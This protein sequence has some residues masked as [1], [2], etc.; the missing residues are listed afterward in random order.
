MN[1]CTRRVLLGTL[2]LMLALEVGAAQDAT[3]PQQTVICLAPVAVEAT[4]A[5]M[6]P[7]AAVRDAFMNFLTGPSLAVQ[8]LNARL[9]SQVR[10]EAK[11]A[12]CRLAGLV[13]VTLAPQSRISRGDLVGRCPG[14][15]RR[16]APSGWINRQ[17]FAR[18]QSP[19]TWQT[20]PS[21]SRSGTDGH[22]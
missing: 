1:R 20:R 18:R 8:P 22:G 7:V 19:A 3:A 4:P 11:L 13:L 2:P 16:L 10:E 9:Q 21:P 12:G 5:G 14:G 6:D 15:A 17:F